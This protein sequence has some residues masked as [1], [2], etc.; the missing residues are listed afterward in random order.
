MNRY[1]LLLLSLLIVLSSCHFFGGERVSG[2]GNVT[3]AERQVG[4]FNSVELSGSL[5][6][7]LK[8]EPSNSVKVEAD[9]NLMPFIEVYTEG[10]TLVIREKRGYNLRPTREIIVYASAAEFRHL[11][12]SGSGNIFTDNEISSNELLDMTVSGSGGAMLQLNT[13]K[14]N[15]KVSGSGS[16][17]L[18]GQAQDMALSI[19][20]SG[21]VNAFDV[22]AE[23]VT[24]GVS[25]SGNANVNAN[26]KLEAR[27][28]GSGNVSYKGN[29]SVDK[30]TSGSGDVNKVN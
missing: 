3:T 6:V 23:N 20:G 25:G 12:V 1:P 16:V 26:K 29:P 30:S 22:N 18:K 27:V 4:S 17:T 28:S 21:S 14:L 10:N 15:V 24:V 7:H 8:Q 5:N 9:A 11:S 19:S 2:D 13:S